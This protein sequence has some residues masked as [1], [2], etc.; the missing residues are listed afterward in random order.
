MTGLIDQ[1]RDA[2]IKK[3]GAVEVAKVEALRVAKAAVSASAT[4]RSKSRSGVRSHAEEATLAA[5]WC[6]LG[7]RAR[8][9]VCCIGDW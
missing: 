3:F 8:E 7:V 5:E 6:D 9:L 4:Q 1:A 2:A